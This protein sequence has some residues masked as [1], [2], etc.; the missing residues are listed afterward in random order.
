MASPP[1]PLTITEGFSIIKYKSSSK[2]EVIRKILTELWPFFISFW[3]NCSF[4]SI[5]FEGMQQFHS[6][7]TEG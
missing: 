2:M 4:R 5:T 7:F 1:G 3:L 6:N